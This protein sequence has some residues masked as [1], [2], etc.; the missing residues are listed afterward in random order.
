MQYSIRN[1]SLNHLYKL[2]KTIK[3]NASTNES[4]YERGIAIKLNYTKLTPLISGVVMHMATATT[5][6]FIHL[7]ST[8]YIEQMLKLKREIKECIH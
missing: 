3:S 5:H 1:R 2:K 6:C 4:N 8:D 7:K